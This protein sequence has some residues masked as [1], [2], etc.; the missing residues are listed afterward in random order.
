MLRNLAAAATVAVACSSLHASVR[1]YLI[2]NSLTNDPNPGRMP[3]LAVGL[4]RS[5]SVGYHIRGS[6]SLTQLEQSPGEA[7]VQFSPAR[8]DSALSGQ[9]WDYVSLQPYR[10]SVVAAAGA[11]SRFV[12]SIRSNP[13]NAGTR[14]YLYQTWMQHGGTGDFDF[15]TLWLR[16]ES[17]AGDVNTYATRDYW[18][19]LMAEVNPNPGEIEI[20]IVPVG[21][22]VYL[23]EREIRAGR[24]PGLDNVVDLYRDAIHFNGYGKYLAAMTHMMVIYQQPFIGYPASSRYFVDGVST[25]TDEQ[26]RVM[27]S[28]AW[29]AVRNHPYS[30]VPEPATLGVLIGGAMLLLRRRA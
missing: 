3:E 28:V 2:G 23:L 6:W 24:M 17:V 20:G 25:I 1:G 18:N 9:A 22:A 16:P 27:Q 26:A 19:Q 7:L 5:F 15:D 30:L 4:G 11:A 14:V 12:T 13:A 8:H 29:E 10:E 21:E